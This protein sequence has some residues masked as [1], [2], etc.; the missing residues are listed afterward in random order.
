LALHR[1]DIFGREAVDN[2][3]VASLYKRPWHAAAAWRVGVPRSP[4][5]SSGE[6]PATSSGLGGC[7]GF[8]GFQFPYR[9]RWGSAED[10]THLVSGCLT[11]ESEER[12]T[13]TAESLRAAFASGKPNRAK[14]PEE[15]SAVDVSGQHYDRD[16]EQSPE[17]T[18]WD[19]VKR[20]DQPR[21]NL[22]NLR[23]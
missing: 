11:S 15:T 4:S 21:S 12:E 23:V 3:G 22:F 9:P 8:G 19:L 2:G 5:L 6:H 16:G 17:R 7:A 18:E 14:R 1:N 20:C 13:W 10:G